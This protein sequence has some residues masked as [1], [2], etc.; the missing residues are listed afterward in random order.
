MPEMLDF[1]KH[2]VYVWG[3]VGLSLA[4]LAWN[5]LLARIQLR[6]AMSTARRRLAATEERK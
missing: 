2:N 4:I 3:T 5:V 1:G 6:N